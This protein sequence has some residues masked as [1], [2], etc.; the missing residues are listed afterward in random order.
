MD[1]RLATSQLWLCQDAVSAM[2]SNPLWSLGSNLRTSCELTTWIWWHSVETC[3]GWFQKLEDV[4]NPGQESD[5]EKKR[6][7]SPKLWNRGCKWTLRKKNT[8]LDLQAR[9][10]PGLRNNVSTGAGVGH[11]PVRFSSIFSIFSRRLDTAMAMACYYMNLLWM[12]WHISR[13]PLHILKENEL[14][15]F[16]FVIGTTLFFNL[17]MKTVSLHFLSAT[18]KD[19]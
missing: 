18:P 12:F 10:L 14:H 6:H 3:G 11:V 19:P 7:H 2:I 8:C 5:K 1:L 15:Q 13:N 16:A 17:R 9:R 4:A